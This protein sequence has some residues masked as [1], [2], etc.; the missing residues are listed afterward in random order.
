M[1]CLSYICWVKAIS[2][3]SAEARGPSAAATN[4]LE[5]KN[6][7][8]GPKNIYDV[9]THGMSVNQNK[10]KHINKMAYDDR[11]HNKKIEKD[12]MKKK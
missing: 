10:S 2:W 3:P 12:K 1:S 4:S 6:N 8:N 7:S 11:F 9:F 5:H